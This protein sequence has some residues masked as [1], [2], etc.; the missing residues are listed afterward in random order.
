MS[1]EQPIKNPFLPGA[2]RPPSEEPPPRLTWAAISTSGTKKPTND[3]A[4]LA[5]ASD[6]EGTQILEAEGSRL[7]NKDDLLFAVA[8]GMGGG[9][10]GDVASTLLLD[11]LTRI[12]PSVFSKAA[13]GLYPDYLT[14]LENVVHYVH[15]AINEEAKDDPEK[16]GMA[17][18]IAL[19]WFTP[20]NM[21]LA[22]AGDSRIYRLRDGDLRQ[23][24]IDHSF[25]WQR[26]KRGDCTERE[27][28]ANPRRS[29]LYQIMGGG[30][31]GV[32]PHIASVPYLPGDRY[33]ICSDGLVDGLWDK[34]IWSIMENPHLAAKDT[35]ESLMARAIANDG[36]DDTTLIVINLS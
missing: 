22:N 31:Q 12:I 24:S 32:I 2:S 28:R 16:T 14:H 15:R 17:A 8:D 34:H 35:A 36:T 11:E 13:A 20:E 25:A 6:P 9:R 4:W 27:Y 18:T 7:L 29:A 10:A 26:M 3:D 30:H 23:L 5:L 1:E 21:Y 19:A 33:L